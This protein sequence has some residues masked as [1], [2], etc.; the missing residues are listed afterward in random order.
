VW[1]RELGNEDYKGTAS[2]EV[3]RDARGAAVRLVDEQARLAKVRE[4]L[5]RQAVIL[6]CFE[7]DERECHRM[8]VKQRL[9]GEPSISREGAR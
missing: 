8:Y 7:A 5:E 3:R 1:V 9:A 2:P 4:I 6:L